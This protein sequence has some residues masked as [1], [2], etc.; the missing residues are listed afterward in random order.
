[1]SGT[2]LVNSA[3]TNPF[4]TGIDDS[5]VAL[6]L[7]EAW[8]PS[9]DILAYV[10]GSPKASNNIE[11]VPFADPTSLPRASVSGAP[12]MRESLSVT[13]IALQQKFYQTQIGVDRQIMDYSA[14]LKPTL[15]AQI[16]SF[17]SGNYF[18]SLIEQEAMKALVVN[19]TRSNVD[20][21]AVFATDHP[22][23]TGNPS[24]VNYQT[25]STTQSNLSTSTALSA[26]NLTAT[27]KKLKQL[28]TANGRAITTK[29]ITLWVTPE[30]ETLA[31]HLLQAMYLGFSSTFGSSDSGGSHS[32][33]F[34]NYGI[35]LEV[36]GNYP[37]IS[38]SSAAT[39]WYLSSGTIQPF[40]VKV[41]Q[42]PILAKLTSPTDPNLVQTNQYVVDFKTS[43]VVDVS[44]HLAMI[45]CTA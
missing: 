26:V 7:N 40:V 8:T 44:H 20:G 45:K 25:N 31:R 21:K 15:E 6:F 11:V 43:M 3:L 24:Q 14:A 19:S 34:S 5:G 12:P 28:A 38:G 23:S 1:M 18:L 27:I 35:K 32:N 33:M 29:Q 2:P 41:A 37:V 42:Q 4:A 9:V 13:S 17:G 39:D 36:M 10:H 30:L 22:V 16:N